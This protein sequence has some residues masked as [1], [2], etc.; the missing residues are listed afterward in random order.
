MIDSAYWRIQDV[1]FS[2]LPVDGSTAR[3]G[4]PGENVAVLPP[5]RQVAPTVINTARRDGPLLPPGV[6]GTGTGSTLPAG[7]YQCAIA[8][9]TAFGETGLSTVA[10]ATLTA[11]QNL[12]YAPVVLPLDGV[13]VSAIVY[14]YTDANDTVWKTG[15]STGTGGAKT[16]IAPGSAPMSGRPFVDHIPFASVSWNQVTSDRLNVEE[17]VNADGTPVDPTTQPPTCTITATTPPLGSGGAV[18]VRV[19]YQRRIAQ[20]DYTVPT[21]VIRVP[22]QFARI[23]TLGYYTGILSDNQAGGDMRQWRKQSEEY[24]Q[25]AGLLYAQ[26]VPLAFPQE[27]QADDYLLTGRV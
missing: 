8:Y 5:H 23:A 4:L 10:A 11:G 18:A 20:P 24:R 15:T 26:S 22:Q 7:V 14:Y 1:V 6:S 2:D 21:S 12:A 13:P 19:W 9:R 16:F 17:Q 27:M 3:W 25:Q